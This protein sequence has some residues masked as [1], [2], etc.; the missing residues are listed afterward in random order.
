MR[1]IGNPNVKQ[2]A[3]SNTFVSVL[4]VKLHVVKD[5]ETVKLHVV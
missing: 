2:A 1:V 3:D 4:F 5:L